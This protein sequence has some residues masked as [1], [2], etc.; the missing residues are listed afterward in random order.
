MEAALTG[1]TQFK[2]SNPSGPELS[3]MSLLSWGRRSFVYESRSDLGACPR[4]AP[5]CS[6]LCREWICACSAGHAFKLF[7]VLE[8]VLSKTCLFYIN[9]ILLYKSLQVPI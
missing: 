8:Q 9:S 5:A 7:A 6:V 1:F 4:V 2:P 3:K